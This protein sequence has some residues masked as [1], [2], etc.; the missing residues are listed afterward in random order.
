M[1]VTNKSHLIKF[2]I[3]LIYSFVNIILIPHSRELKNRTT[4][5]PVKIK[6]LPAD[7][8]NKIAAG[9]IIHR[10][11]N[12]IKE[13]LENSIDAGAKNIKISITDGGLKE[14]SITDDG[15]GIN[16][17]DLE[18]LAKRHTTSKIACVEDLCGVETFGFRGEALASLSY[19]CR[20]LRVITKT[21]WNPED[22]GPNTSNIAFTA[23]YSKEV[24]LPNTKKPNPS[25]PS[26]NKP[27]TSGTQ[28]LAQ[29]LFYNFS[30]R[31]N[32]LKIN[33]E[34]KHTVEVCK[35][36]ALH[37]SLDGVNIG[38]W[39]KSSKNSKSN[40]SGQK[41]C[42]KSDLNLSESLESD[43]ENKKHPDELHLIKLATQQLYSTDISKNLIDI[44]KST[45]TKQS[46]TAT[47]QS[48]ATKD[49]HKLYDE[50]LLRNYLDLSS[51]KCHVRNFFSTKVNYSEASGSANCKF[52]LFINNR[53]VESNV[54]KKSLG[55][56]YNK[57]SVKKFANSFSIFS[58]NSVL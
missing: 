17:Y 30:A 9:E 48:S 24:M 15:C 3:I 7:V 25:H 27:E 29:N 14:I 49:S 18:I 2:S 21:K 52:L 28:I 56:T 36:Y 32:S 12:A 19:V 35:S 16:F 38:F 4:K 46:D 43:S 37:Y 41:L 45:Q 22:S 33:E 42:F 55:L 34:L 1:T 10:P 11:A 47:S 26:F 57:G 50:S 13:L 5:M 6:Q 40:Q 44:K 54:I 51:Y 23:D 20:P 8:I 31:L 53:L 39:Q 58:D